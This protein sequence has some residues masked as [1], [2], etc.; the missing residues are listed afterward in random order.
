[1][2]YSA[3]FSTLQEVINDQDESSSINKPID[4]YGF[5]DDHAYKKS[6]VAKS[7]VGE[8][9]TMGELE[10]CAKR[11]KNWVDGN[12]LKMNDSKTEFIMFCSSKM[13][14]KCITTDININ[15]TKVKKDNVIRY[16]GV[17]MYDVLSFKYHVKMKCK[18]PMFNLVHIKRLRPS[19]TVETANILVMGLVISHIDYANSILIGVPDVT[20]KQLQCI[21]NMAAK[22]VL[23]ADKYASP[24][25]CMK[26][27]HWLPICKRV[28]HKVLTIVYKCIKGITPKYL[29]DLLKKCIPSS[30]DCIPGAL[31][32]NWWYH[33]LPDKLLQQ[34][35]SVC[36]VPAYGTAC[37]LKSLWHQLWTNS[38]LGLEHI[39]LDR[40]MI[41]NLNVCSHTVMIIN[42]HNKC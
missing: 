10:N 15:G 33:G 7:Q 22:V 9:N 4:L 2:L 34:E 12:R 37:Q 27:L 30:L 19:L 38:K 1:M 3:Y 13:L 32:P 16:L 36:V 29:Q 5:A 24:R 11:I 42:Y 28:E 8:I 21:Q 6:F 23:Q 26:N 31:Q 18:S 20:I 25:D 17:W 40:F 35:H 14:S 39:C 41:S